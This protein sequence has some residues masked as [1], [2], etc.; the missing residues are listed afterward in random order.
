MRAPAG[1]RTRPRCHGP[2]TTS[3][4]LADSD[5]TT[6]IAPTER[7][8]Q[9]RFTFPKSEQSWVVVDAFDK[10]SY[11]KVL[12][13]QRRIVGYSTR[14]ARGPLPKNFRNWFVIEFDKPFRSAE[15]W[16]GDSVLPASLQELE[17]GHAA[18]SSASRPRPA[19]R[20]T[21]AWRRPSSAWNR[22]S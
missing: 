21:C 9:F 8:A 4:Y 11:V 16:N 13:V 14:Y 17:A 6:E 5:V 18:P 12:P 2:T 15:L 20:S 19:K 7:A 1:S 22:P 3:V 10:G